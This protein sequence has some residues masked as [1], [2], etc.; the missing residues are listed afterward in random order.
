MASNNSPGIV[1]RG[2]KI[3]QEGA[4]KALAIKKAASLAKK[5]RKADMFVLDE[6]EGDGS[7]DEQEQS[8]EEGEFDDFI[9]DNDQSDEE[10]EAS[11][12]AEIL[13]SFFAIKFFGYKKLLL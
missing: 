4:L 11:V 6:A 1:L 2:R 10:E 3:S 7:E 9:V 5:K 8:E 12:R 13:K